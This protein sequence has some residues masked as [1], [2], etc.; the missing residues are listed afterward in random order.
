MNVIINVSIIIIVIIIPLRLFKFLLLSSL[1]S[2]IYCCYSYCHKQHIII[3]HLQ[4]IQANMD[5]SQAQT[6]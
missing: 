4:P 3:Q 5:T 1:I 2:L 6:P